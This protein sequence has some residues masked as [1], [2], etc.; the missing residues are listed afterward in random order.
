MLSQRYALIHQRLMRHDFF[1]PTDL[2]RSS[3]KLKL[4][5]IESLL[6]STHDHPVLLL[7]LL[8]QI[9]EGQW[10]LE[11]PSGQIR[12]SF[13]MLSKVDDFF[14]AE[15]CVL[16]VEGRLHDG[17]FYVAHVGNPVL[18]QRGT[19]LAAIRQQVSHPAYG[20]SLLL[21]PAA[22]SGDAGD[23]SSFVFLSDV[24]LDQPRVVQHLEALFARYEKFPPSKLPTFLLMGSFSSSREIP[25]PMEELAGLVATFTNLRRHGRFVLVPGPNDAPGYTLP[26]TNSLLQFSSSSSSRSGS[27]SNTAALF[28]RMNV[29]WATNPCRIRNHRTGSEIVVFRFDLLHLF[30]RQQ[31]F[32][33]RG[34]AAKQKKREDGDGKSMSEHDDNDNDEEANGGGDDVS[35]HR[36]VPSHVRLIKTV[37]GQAH[38]LPVSGVPVAWN[39]D[40]ALRLYPLP[41]LVVL[42]GDGSGFGSEGAGKYH[43]VYEGCRVIH[44]GSAVSGS[45][46]IYR[47]GCA[48]EDD[49]DNDAGAGPQVEF[50]QL[51]VEK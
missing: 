17:I 2:S 42:G 40:H 19:S 36:D 26:M 5:P 35:R 23:Y 7:G 16:V 32:L 11:D 50:G 21:A 29:E 41:S 22:S 44:P 8:L 13:Q 3:A 25:A 47:E 48:D 20:S 30:Q 24:H 39:Y 12:V 27:S 4:V 37:L 33:H 46:A 15:H 45:F 14:V 10:Y 31:L 28:G 51:G 1:R 49:D 6:G 9:E 18:E 43:E 38:L 34:G